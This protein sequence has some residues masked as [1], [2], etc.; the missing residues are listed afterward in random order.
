MRCSDDRTSAGADPPG[1][2]RDQARARH[3]SAARRWS[4]RLA[5]DTV[6]KVLAASGAGAQAI[7][8]ARGH[9]ADLAAAEYP[10]RF[11]AYVLDAPRGINL[12]TSV[13]AAA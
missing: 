9:V 13:P 6:D 4:Q 7:S 8:H 2:Q 11:D 12:D 1:G 5:G 10:A 3:Q